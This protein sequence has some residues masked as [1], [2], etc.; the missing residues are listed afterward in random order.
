MTIQEG[1]RSKRSRTRV[2]VDRRPPFQVDEHPDRSPTS[3]RSQRQRLESDLQ[4]APLWRTGDLLH[5]VR[6]TLPHASLAATIRPQTKILA[7]EHAHGRRTRHLATPRTFPLFIKPQQV[8]Q[9]LGYPVE[10]VY[11]RVL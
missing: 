1:H 3:V 11:P 10:F 6:I 7:A 5:S 2:E 4:T 9:A 8:F